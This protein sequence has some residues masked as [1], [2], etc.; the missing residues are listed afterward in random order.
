MEFN[1][2]S[3]F[4]YPFEFSQE[5]I[6][7]FAKVSGDHNPIHLDEDFA[8]QS[9]FGKRIAHGMFGASIISKVMGMHFPGP[10][11][12]Y[13]KQSLEFMRPMF[14]GEKYV[15]EVKVEEIDEKKRAKLSTVIKDL[16]TKKVCTKGEAQILLA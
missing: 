3:T 9:R 2:G 1:V 6:V 5:D 11:S 13:L 14:A 8:S 7:L 10:G 15:V 16:T 12:V 4:E